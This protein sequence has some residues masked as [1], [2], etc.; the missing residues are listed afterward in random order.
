[1][2]LKWSKTPAQQENSVCLVGA[3][4]R[5]CWTQSM[6]LNG[7]RLAFDRHG[8][9][10]TLR[11]PYRSE[12]RGSSPR[13]DRVLPCRG[14]ARC[15]RTRLSARRASYGDIAA[16]FNADISIIES[17]H[18]QRWNG[19][20]REPIE[21]RYHRHLLSQRGQHIAGVD[22]TAFRPQSA[23]ED[24]GG[25]IVEQKAIDGFGIDVLPDL[26]QPRG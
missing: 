15:A 7:T 16:G 24:G 3:S 22:Q 21:E 17:N 13:S 20:G 19:Q 11:P 14:S 5:R 12:M 18:D 25:V 8:W 10:S 23:V 26:I 1:M 6:R 9:F 4:S 2:T